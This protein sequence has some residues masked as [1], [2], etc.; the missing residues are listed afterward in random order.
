MSQIWQVRLTDQAEQDLIA[1]K[2]RGARPILNGV[3]M[4]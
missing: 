1:L 4:N 2:Q 3:L